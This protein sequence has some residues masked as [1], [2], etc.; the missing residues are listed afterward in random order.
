MPDWLT[1]VV[2]TVAALA[3]IVWLV[4]LVVPGMVPGMALGRI[5]SCD[6]TAAECVPPADGRD[7]GRGSPSRIG[8]GL[9][10]HLRSLAINVLMTDPAKRER[11]A[12]DVLAE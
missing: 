7:L 12:L 6:G 8:L 9:A 4:E 1:S 5:P 11:A 2:I 3:L 10:V